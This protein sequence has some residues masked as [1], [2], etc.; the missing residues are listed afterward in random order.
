MH[1]RGGAISFAI[2]DLH[3]H[4]VG[5]VLDRHGIAVRVGHHCAWPT[6]RRYGVPATTRA[7]FYVYNDTDDVDALLAG[8]EQV[9]RFFR[10]R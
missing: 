2:N 9:Q 4:D 7:S 1:S 10:V 6:C 3:P 5:E 8:I